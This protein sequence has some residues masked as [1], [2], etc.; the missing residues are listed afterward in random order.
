MRSI[1]TARVRRG[2]PRGLPG[3]RRERRVDSSQ[4]WVA[5]RSRFARTGSGRG[6]GYL[7]RHGT[8]LPVN[9]AERPP[10]VLGRR[11]SS[12]HP[13]GRR[14]FAQSELTQSK[15]H[16]G[17]PRSSVCVGRA[18]RGP[19]V[20]RRARSRLRCRHCRRRG[21]PGSDSRSRAHLAS[22]VDLNLFRLGILRQ[23]EAPR[24]GAIAALVAVPSFVLFVPLTLL[25]AAQ[26]QKPVL[27]FHDQIVF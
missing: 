17:H 19:R 6:D 25:L 13:L 20:R 27:Q 10:I 21:S 9:P 16:A 15:R 18:A 8:L 2:L 23:G 14:E 7:R 5:R 11:L 3:P 26:G 1:S 12:D 24:E 22:T 4:G